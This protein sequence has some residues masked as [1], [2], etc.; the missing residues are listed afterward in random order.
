MMTTQMI[1]GRSSESPDK[2]LTFQGLPIVWDDTLPEN[3]VMLRL[4]FEN[5]S[6]TERLIK[7][8]FLTPIER[9]E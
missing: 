4:P 3:T 1:K 8:G 9:S 7:A 6:L 2:P 5:E